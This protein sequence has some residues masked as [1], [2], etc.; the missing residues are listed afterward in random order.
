MSDVMIRSAGIQDNGMEVDEN[1]RA[2]VASVS[3]D[4]LQDK[5]KNGEAFYISIGAHEVI[6]GTSPAAG[7]EYVIGELYNNTEGDLL[8]VSPECWVR[9]SINEITPTFTISSWQENRFNQWLYQGSVLNG[10]GTT[11]IVKNLNRTSSETLTNRDDGTAAFLHADFSNAV[12]TPGSSDIGYICGFYISHIHGTKPMLPERQGII[13]GKGQ[14]WVISYKYN[15]YES[16]INHVI[17][18][19]ASVIKL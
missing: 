10:I 15:E 18:V 4:L 8:V 5:L 3:E 12:A 9:P 6:A 7:T 16:P 11:A 2:Q 14:S 17:G 19:R 1:G 13:I